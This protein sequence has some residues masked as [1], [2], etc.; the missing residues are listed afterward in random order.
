MRDAHDAS[1]VDDA[2]ERGPSASTEQPSMVEALRREHHEG[3]RTRA[4]VEVHLRS[5][6]HGHDDDGRFGDRRG[7]VVRHRIDAER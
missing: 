6:P 1:V 5:D 2:S 7:Q 3:A 4:G